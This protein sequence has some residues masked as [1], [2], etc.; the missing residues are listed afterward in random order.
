MASQL[1]QH[2]FNP[3]LCCICQARVQ[4]TN[5][6]ARIN[7]HI[8]VCLYC[9]PPGMPEIFPESKKLA[10]FSNLKLRHFSPVLG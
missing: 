6:E 8:S 4:V 2:S 3:F 1:E 9:Q 10:E 7:V 5:L